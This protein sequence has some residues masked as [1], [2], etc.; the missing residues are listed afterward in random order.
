[1]EG[2]FYY[3]SFIVGVAEGLGGKL[4][5]TDSFFGPRPKSSEAKPTAVRRGGRGGGTLAA[6][7]GAGGCS[8]TK[9]YYHNPT[10]KAK[11]IYQDTPR[12]N[13]SKDMA[14]LTS[15]IRRT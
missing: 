11:R 10:A 6:G 4:I 7:L 1:M 3:G 9:K 14:T 12:Y 2:S 8:S 15:T 5:R 13:P